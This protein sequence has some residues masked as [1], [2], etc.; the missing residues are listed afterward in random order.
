[1]FGWGFI[2]KKGIEWEK[3]KLPLLIR[4]RWSR[5][6]SIGVHKY[7]LIANSEVFSAMFSHKNTTEFREGRIIIK[8][9]TIVA[10][11]QM[12]YYM[13]RGKMSDDYDREQD[14][15]PLLAIAHKYQIKPLM[16]FNEQILVETLV[17]TNGGVSG[18]REPGSV[19][20]IYGSRGQRG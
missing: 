16:D 13:Y 5:D 1:M 14:A 8:D 3:G 2:W 10:V 18:S 6:P 15:L 7:I 9:S 19:V 11:R 12:V 17:S 20:K 4:W